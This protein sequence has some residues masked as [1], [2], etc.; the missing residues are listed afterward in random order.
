MAECVMHPRASPCVPVR[1]THKHT[2]VDLAVL[3]SVSGHS[4]C[5]ICWLLSG[6]DTRKNFFKFEDNANSVL[7]LYILIFGT[8]LGDKVCP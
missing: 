3:T 8:C 4:G 2:V 7:I 6:H 5:D 1:A